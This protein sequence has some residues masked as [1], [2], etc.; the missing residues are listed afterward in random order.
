MVKDATAGAQH[1]ELGDGYQSE[2]TNFGF[3]TNAVLSTEKAVAA[4]S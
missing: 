2:L 3:I 4:I 1:P